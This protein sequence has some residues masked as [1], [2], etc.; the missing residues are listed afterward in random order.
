NLIRPFIRQAQQQLAATDDAPNAQRPLLE[1]VLNS[2]DAALESWQNWETTKSPSDE[3]QDDSNGANSFELVRIETFDVARPK[4][5]GPSSARQKLR[6]R[7]DVS[8]PQAMVWG[9]LACAAGFAISLVRE[10]KQGTLLRLKVAPVNRAQIL[11]GKAAACF[12]AVLTVLLVLTLLG[13]G[14]GMRPLNPWQL[15]ASACSIAY[16]FVGVMML[17]S[18]VGKSEE[19]VSGAAWMANM[20]MAMFGGGMIPLMFMPGFMKTLSNFSPVKWSV[21]A[22]EGSIWRGFTWRELLGPYV[23]LLAVGSICM[24]CGTLLLSRTHD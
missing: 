8:F 14:L 24:A 17:M 19:A 7:W 10:R 18:T 16:C 15:A 22:L 5:D 6:S 12:L 13:V 4:Q 20:L 11:A 3:L 9:V 23:I 2:L 1:G 21:L